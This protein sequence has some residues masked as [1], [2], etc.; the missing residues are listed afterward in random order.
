MSEKAEKA[1][2]QAVSFEEAM[3]ELESIVK[4]LETND[5]PLEKAIDLFQKGMAYSKLCHDKLEKVSDKM[6]RLMHT[7]GDSEPFSISGDE[8]Q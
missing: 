7:E 4:Q 1:G 8:G 3:V 2:E 5:V 6:D